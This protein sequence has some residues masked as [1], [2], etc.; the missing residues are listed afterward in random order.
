MIRQ[1]ASV[2]V[3]QE[4]MVRGYLLYQYKSTNADAKLRRQLQ[5]AQ[6]GEEVLEDGGGAT[7]VFVLLY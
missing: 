2:C 7:P 3:L 6:E 1:L 5:G 4:A